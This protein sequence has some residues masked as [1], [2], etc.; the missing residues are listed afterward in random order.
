MQEDVNPD[1]VWLDVPAIDDVWV[2]AAGGSDVAVVLGDGLV[3]HGGPDQM[4]S[5]LDA[6]L[7]QMQAFMDTRED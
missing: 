2:G 5:V 3:L 7:S 4:V 6:A 1:R